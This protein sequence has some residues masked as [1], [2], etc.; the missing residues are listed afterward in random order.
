MRPRLHDEGEKVVFGHRGNYD[1]DAVLDLIL[2]RPETARFVVR[3]LWR[4][5]V[6]PDPDPATVEAIAAQFRA[7]DYDLRVALRALLLA[8]QFWDPA[9]RGT[10]VRSPVELVVGTLH[11]LELTPA[12]ALPFAIAT[13][14]M[15]ENLFAPPNVKGWPGGERWIDTSTLLARKQFLARLARPA[16]MRAGDTPDGPEAMLASATHDAVN[17]SDAMLAAG[18]PRNAANGRAAF[19]AASATRNP[20]NV[21]AAP[22]SSSPS[23]TSIT[24]SNAD[25]GTALRERLARSV[26][27]ALARLAF[28][29]ARWLRGVP[30]DDLPAR[31]A[32]AQRVLL[33]LSPVTPDVAEARAERDP[34]LLVRAALLDP[35]YQLK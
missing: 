27:S 16:A 31:L 8:P 4:E 20:A 28:D 25:A 1:G 17:A 9:N 24:L 21:T 23:A 2:A 11:T 10:L 26:E 13:A 35:V 7:H 30:G 22:S 18:A 6:S 34:A 15:G 29:P 33:P 3:K 14:G 19:P 32:N 12:A 5:F